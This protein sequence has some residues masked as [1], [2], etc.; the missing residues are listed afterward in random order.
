[1]RAISKHPPTGGHET[2]GHKFHQG[3][4]ADTMCKTK[5]Y[6]IKHE[7]D[8][9]GWSEERI[10]RAEKNWHYCLKWLRA[11]REHFAE[12]AEVFKK[13]EQVYRRQAVLQALSKSKQ[14]LLPAQ[15]VS[16]YHSAGASF[17]TV[18]NNS[19][20]DVDTAEFVRILR[21]EYERLK[22]IEQRQQ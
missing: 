6:K 17:A 20:T 16:T 19:E 1:M 14:A 15:N 7:L 8:W 18:D 2:G 11:F 21:G 4:Y 22:K 10:A 5:V 12:P 9:P 3:K 13:R